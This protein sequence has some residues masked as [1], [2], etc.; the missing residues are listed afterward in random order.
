MASSTSGMITGR[1]DP[2][3]SSST[4]ST[5]RPSVGSALARL[6]VMTT[7]TPPRPVLPMNRPTGIAMIM[8]SARASRENSRCSSSR[9]GMPSGPVQLAGLP[10]KSVSQF[11]TPSSP[12]PTA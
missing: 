10:K 9:I 1:I 6:A 5:S 12:A 7:M 2:V 8:A 3:P 11:T 4:N